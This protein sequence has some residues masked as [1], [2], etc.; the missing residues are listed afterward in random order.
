MS[1]EHQEGEREA[2]V[3]MAC[4]EEERD[5]WRQADFCSSPDQ[6][7]S[8]GGT[9]VSNSLGAAQGKQQ[10][11]VA[12]TSMGHPWMGVLWALVAFALTGNKVVC[13]CR[14][15]PAWLPYGADS[16]NVWGQE[17]KRDPIKHPRRLSWEHG[18]LGEG[19]GEEKSKSWGQSTAKAD[20]LQEFWSPRRLHVHWPGPCPSSLTGVRNWAR[21]QVPSQVRAALLEPPEN[22][23]HI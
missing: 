22:G 14:D 17:I 3:C 11:A 5:S 16:T 6:W 9:L 20:L 4:E 15:L 2:M 12:S 18:Y 19:L 1:N 10:W 8:E 21:L 13:I 23:D 7:P